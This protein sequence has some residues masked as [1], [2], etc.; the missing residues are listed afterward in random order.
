MSNLRLY[1]FQANVL[2]IKQD[3]DDLEKYVI[4]SLSLAGRTSVSP[5]HPVSGE[6]I[7]KEQLGHIE[8]EHRQLT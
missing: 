6:G 2:F 8:W 1:A 5:E 4:L 3:R 7:V